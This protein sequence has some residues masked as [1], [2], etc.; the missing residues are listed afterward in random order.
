[1]IVSLLR[2]GGGAIRATHAA[3]GSTVPAVIIVYVAIIIVNARCCVTGI[4]V[5]TLYCSVSVC[6]L[7]VIVIVMVV[8]V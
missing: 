5:Q 3:S 8:V 4:C 2:A 1:M 6:A 7:V